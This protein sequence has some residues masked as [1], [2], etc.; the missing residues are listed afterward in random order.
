MDALFAQEV[1]KR[2]GDDLMQFLLD[3][4]PIYAQALH[5]RDQVEMDA[6]K[7]R[8]CQ[9]FHLPTDTPPFHALPPQRVDPYGCGFCQCKIVVLDTENASLVCT[10]CGMSGPT[11][12]EHDFLHDPSEHPTTPYLY[13]PCKHMMKHLQ[14]LQGHYLPRMDDHDLVAIKRDLE[15]H[16]PSI[17]H[18]LPFDVFQSL[19]RLKLKDFYQ[20]RLAITRKVNPSY[21]P[22]RL[23][24]DVVDQVLAIFAGCHQRFLN[25]IR[26]GVI[27]RKRNFYPY[28]W[29]IQCLLN[30][31]GVPHSRYH[32]L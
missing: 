24:L 30:H 21:H 4:S 2:Q 28:P 13:E 9:T 29:F 3:A 26:T 11:G 32:R 27:Q 18:A 20:H 25:G 17:H 10:N 19:Q 14:W 7:A 16:H 15:A 5:A 6:C 22:L 23:T 12:F 31:L 1:E 8:F